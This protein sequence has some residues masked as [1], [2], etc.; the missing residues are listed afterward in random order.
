M[1]VSREALVKRAMAVLDEAIWET[2]KS[3]VKA[4]PGLCL[5]LA[6]LYAVADPHCPLGRPSRQDFDDFLAAVTDRTF[7]DMAA[8]DGRFR[9]S[10][11]LPN[12]NRIARRVGWAP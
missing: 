5:A 7:T 1:R 10:E 9:S 8:R 4:G 11:A 2:S 6:Y 12:Y 3:P